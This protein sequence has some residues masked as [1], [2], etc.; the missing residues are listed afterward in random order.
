MFCVPD[1]VVNQVVVRGFSFLNKVLEKNFC[2]YDKFK[3]YLL[4]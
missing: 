4:C 1:F 2:F 3:M